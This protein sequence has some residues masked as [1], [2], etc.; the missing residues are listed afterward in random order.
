LPVKRLGTTTPAEFNGADYTVLATA[1]VTAVCSV[2]TVNK[3]AVG[4]LVTI[5]VEPFDTPGSQFNWSYIVKDLEIGVGQS[6][7]TFRFAVAVGDKIYVSS[8]TATVNFSATAAY[9]QAGRTNVLYQPDQ[10]GFPSVGDIW[11][12]SDDESIQLF[13]GSGFSTIATAAPVGPTGPAGTQGL[14][15]PT[16]PTGAEGFGIKI[17]GLYDTLQAL[18]EDNPT[19]NIGDAY[20]VVDEVYVWSDLN[21]EWA[22]AGALTAG[23]AG[24]TGPAGSQGDVGS[25]GLVGATGATGDIGATGPSGGPTGPQGEIGPI[26]PTGATGPQG[27]TGIQGVTGAT[28]AVSTVAG[29]EGPTGPTGATGVSGGITLAVT[30]NGSS[31]YIINGAS[32]PTLSFIRGHRYVINVNAVGHPFWIQTVSGAYS[33]GDVY[34]TGVTNN[35]TQNGTIIFEVPFDA[36]QLYY[37]C[38]NHSAMAGS[39]TVSDL[40]PA[41]VDGGFDSAQVIETKATNYT[42]TSADAGK[43][44]LNSA[45]ITITVEGLAVGQQVDFLQNVAGQIT[46]VNG[47]GMTLNSK[48][49]NL[50]TVGQYSPAGVKCVAT[51]TYVLVGNLGI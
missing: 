10:P 15:G 14:S 35:G 7:E 22:S 5:A 4:A 46:F 40:G 31:N 34:N 24:P 49:G 27:E 18:E 16:G 38:Q 20:L 25:D 37:V 36:P 47:A 21:Q 39:I 43:L 28:G 12:D 32:N 3:G 17:L 33:A 51:D 41:G 1:D 2:I 45:A 26:G 9:E 8:S 19:A 42:L 23:V 11:I 30:N 48:D 29:P 44:I 50:L 13:N 6:F